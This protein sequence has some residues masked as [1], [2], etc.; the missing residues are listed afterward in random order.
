MP[1]RVLYRNIKKKENM[2]SKD[3]SLDIVEKLE[4]LRKNGTDYLLVTIEPGKNVDRADVWYEL[5]DEA[6]VG[7]LTQA[8]LSILVNLYSK[9]DLI[10]LLFG[11][12]EE[13]DSGEFDNIEP[14]PPPPQKKKKKKEPPTS[15]EGDNL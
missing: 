14:E 2:S 6:S 7:N 11:F 10:N 12:C 9:E 4:L 3:I 13:L 5:N 1:T 8:V 15:N